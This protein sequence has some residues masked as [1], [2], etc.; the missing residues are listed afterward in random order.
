[1]TRHVILHAFFQLYKTAR[2]SYLP[3][4]S[5]AMAT[6]RRPLHP[7][8]AQATCRAPE[9]EPCTYVEVVSLAF[10]SNPV[11]LGRAFSLNDDKSKYV[12]V[13]F[14]SAHNYQPLVEFG[15]T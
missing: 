13:E 3:S 4:L 8:D 1:M 15:G 12:S 11:L 10:D 2:I 6:R 9:L 5:V 14:Y 7:L